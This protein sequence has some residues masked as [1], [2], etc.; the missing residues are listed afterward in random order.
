M[1][2]SGSPQTRVLGAADV[3]HLDDREHLDD[4]THQTTGPDVSLTPSSF[5][6]PGGP[7]VGPAVGDRGVIP[8]R[9]WQT[10]HQTC[11]TPCLM[12]RR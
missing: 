9:L 11:Y 5:S 4:P 2:S 1:R 7:R 10:I 3:T 6:A 12:C 8:H